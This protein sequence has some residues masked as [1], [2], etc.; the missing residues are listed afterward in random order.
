ME[1][2][3]DRAVG[4]WIEKFIGVPACGE[5]SGF[6]FAVADHTGHDQIGIV[7][8]RSVSVYQRVAQLAAF[9]D[10]T[11]RF[12][13]HVAGDSVGPTELTEEALDA[14]LVLLDVR[15]DL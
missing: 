2:G 10:G 14:I 11:G 4:G 6:G 15:I 12:R 5:G 13:G 8:G 9:V 7:E 3:Q 1:D